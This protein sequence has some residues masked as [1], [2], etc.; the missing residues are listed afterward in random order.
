M[1]VLKTH[2]DK[3]L[4][5]YKRYEDKVP[6][7]FFIGGFLFDVLTLS[8]I[9]SLASIVQQAVY[10]LILTLLLVLELAEKQGRL[11][12]T[13]KLNK[14]WD[15][16]EA[17]VHFIFGS[18]LSSYTLFFFKSASY[19]TSLT[20]MAFIASMLVVNEIPK[21]QKFGL[22][23]RFGL[24]SLCY[25]CYFAYLVPILMGFIGII[26]IVLSLALSFACM[27]VPY[28]ILL[29]KNYSKD[30]LK[31]WILL[32]TLA[33]TAVFVSFYIFQLIP[34]VPLALNQ[35][36]IYHRAEKKNGTY[37]LNYA[38]PWWKFW[39]NGA[40]TFLYRDGDKLNCFFSIFSPNNFKDTV[41]IRWY[42]N[43]PRMG[44]SPTDAIP[45]AISGGRDEGF[46]GVAIKS[47]FQMGEWQV[48]VETNDNRE[49]GRLNFEV[50]LDDSTDERQ[51]RED[52]F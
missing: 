13:G 41:K 24:L 4:N 48:R 3:A 5:I 36:G 9:D 35:I 25:I 34:P 10:L 32:P 31:G 38:R 11:N 40:Q 30:V 7:A 47:N 50:V 49:I 12:L 44:W 27:M 6:A 45:V 51:F 8:R 23:M 1:E 37:V 52:V 33:I 29:K 17:A 18:L 2:R 26:P 43:D 21:F 16:H 20:F 42:F 28:W 14:W 22:V 46:R 19:A 39:Q 15:Y